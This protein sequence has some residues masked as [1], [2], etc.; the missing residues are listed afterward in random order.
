MDIP[1]NRQE[2]TK[3]EAVELFKNQGYPDKSTLLGKY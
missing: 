1:Y 3:N 2:I